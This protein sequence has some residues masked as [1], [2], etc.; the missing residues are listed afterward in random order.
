MATKH[1][2]KEHAI[3]DNTRDIEFDIDINTGDNLTSDPFVCTVCKKKLYRVSREAYWTDE[4]F[5]VI[6]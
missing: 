4:N 2:C 3:P 1:K 5:N 6:E